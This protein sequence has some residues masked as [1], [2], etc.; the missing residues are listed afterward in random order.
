MNER[1]NMK[2]YYVEFA[3]HANTVLFAA[4]SWFE[5]KVQSFV[6]KVNTSGLGVKRWAF[7]QFNGNN[8]WKA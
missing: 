6:P 4:H 7:P 1:E 8:H 5:I 2:V 3:K